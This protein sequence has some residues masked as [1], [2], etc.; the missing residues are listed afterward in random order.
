[1]ETVQA[2]TIHREKTA[3]STF[4]GKPARFLFVVMLRFDRLA[5]PQAP[6]SI[7][8]RSA[9][10]LLTW[11]RLD[12]QGRPPSSRRRSF[13]T[14]GDVGVTAMVGGVAGGGL[15]PPRAIAFFRLPASSTMRERSCAPGSRRRVGG[16]CEAV[17]LG[18]C[19][20]CRPG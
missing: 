3:A 16:R 11:W 17:V 19:G 6:P 1:M 12:G 10:S 20:G 5:T 15:P 13:S 7:E 4:R 14:S 9:T 8:Q 2:A 18:R